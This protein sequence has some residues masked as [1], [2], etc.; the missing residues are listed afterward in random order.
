MPVPELSLPALK[1]DITV[2]ARPDCVWNAPLSAQ[3]PTACRTAEFQPV[4]CGRFQTYDPTN[5]CARSNSEGP[6]SNACR[7]GSSHGSDEAVSDPIS[8]TLP[9]G[10]KSSMLF[11]QV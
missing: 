2:R 6:R 4:S 1:P 11:D 7:L 10:G 3:P 9:P 8:L 5:R